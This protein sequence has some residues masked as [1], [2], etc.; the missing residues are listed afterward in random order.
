MKH[1]LLGVPRLLNMVPDC[2]T[3]SDDNQQ[4]CSH[5]RAANLPSPHWCI[6]S[7][8]QLAQCIAIA[9]I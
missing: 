6:L 3:T 7:R 2:G 5:C 8:L 4:L 9:K 1:A